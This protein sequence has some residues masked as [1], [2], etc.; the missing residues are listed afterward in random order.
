MPIYYFVK[1]LS[2]YSVGNGQGSK[3]CQR[4]CNHLIFN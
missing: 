1:E 4:Y 3:P 2:D